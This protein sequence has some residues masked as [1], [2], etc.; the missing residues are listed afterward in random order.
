MLFSRQ[1]FLIRFENSHHLEKHSLRADFTSK[2]EGSHGFA[3]KLFLDQE[4]KFIFLSVQKLW[5]YSMD[6]FI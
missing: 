2:P 5:V 1:V 4:C 6:D 3:C